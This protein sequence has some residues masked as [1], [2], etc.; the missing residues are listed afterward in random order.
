MHD[1]ERFLPIQKSI[2]IHVIP[3]FQLLAM[4][5]ENLRLGSSGG[6]IL[7]LPVPGISKIPFGIPNQIAEN[8]R[9]SNKF[10]VKQIES[11]EKDLDKDNPRD[12]IDLYINKMAETKVRRWESSNNRHIIIAEIV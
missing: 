4:V 11:H 12:F 2:F 8:I 9:K 7:F 5:N 1:C 3:L 6:A 10:F